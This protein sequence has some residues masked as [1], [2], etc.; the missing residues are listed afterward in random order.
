M[1]SDVIY[2][3]EKN[4]SFNRRLVKDAGQLLVQHLFLYLSLNF[5][6]YNYSI[7]SVQKNEPEQY[8]IYLRHNFSKAI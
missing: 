8:F 4:V 6:Q 2:I 3:R 5:Y 1:K 7:F